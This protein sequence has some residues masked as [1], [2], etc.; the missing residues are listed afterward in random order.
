M[1]MQIPSTL[2]LLAL[3]CTGGCGTS[4]AGGSSSTMGKQTCRSKVGDAEEAR[5][6]ISLAD[7]LGPLRTRFN[8]DRDKPR[9]V[10]LVSPT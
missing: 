4:M 5:G 3:L 10:A 1:N 9:L 7:S 8:S 2:M 6:L